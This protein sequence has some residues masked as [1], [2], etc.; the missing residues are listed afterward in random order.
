MATVDASD[1]SMPPYS[2]DFISQLL[3]L[4]M[5]H[6]SLRLFNF[7]NYFVLCVGGVSILFLC[8]MGTQT[9]LFSP[10]PNKKKTFCCGI[11]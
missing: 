4:F 10:H 5:F 9:K 11:P 3:F 8:S 6:N 7:Q 1:R 2:L